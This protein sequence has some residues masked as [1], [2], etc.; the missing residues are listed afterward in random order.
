MPHGTKISALPALVTAG[1]ISAALLGSSAATAQER[2]TLETIGAV[3]MASSR[4]DDGR[5]VSPQLRP[6]EAAPA[7][8]QRADD[9]AKAH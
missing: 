3:R 1:L 8:E 4:L 9:P 7:Q 6:V 2:I 5:R